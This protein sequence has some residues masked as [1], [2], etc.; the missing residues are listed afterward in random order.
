MKTL[1]LVIQELVGRDEYFD[2][3]V[4]SFSVK[5]NK[6]AQGELKSIQQ[7]HPGETLKVSAKEQVEK[8]RR[9]SYQVKPPKDSILIPDFGFFT[10]A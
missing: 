7:L 8:L 10:N 6:A 3:F 1:N 9:V 5:G 4:Y 2:C